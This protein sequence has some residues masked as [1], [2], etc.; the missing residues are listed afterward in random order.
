MKFDLAKIGE[1]A[2]VKG[3]KRLPKG[4]EI[5]DEPTDYP[6][7]RVVDFDEDG[8]NPIRIKFI[9][10]EVHEKISRYTITDEDIYVSIAGTIGKVG[11][12][13]HGSQVQI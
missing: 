10:G 9:S 4:A 11:M 12:C 7:L 2:K 13:L 1:I 6:Y 8:L 5:Q 3:G